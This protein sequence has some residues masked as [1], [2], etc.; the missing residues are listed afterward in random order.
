MKWPVPTGDYER[1]CVAG[2]TAALK[3]LADVE[4]EGSHGSG[5]ELKNVILG[6]PRDWDS[7]TGVHVGFCSMVEIAAVAGRRRA[8][9]VADYWTTKLSALRTAAAA[10]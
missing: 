4:A 10:G 6:M 1:D 5:F 8:E 3:Y 9:D 2:Q 7:W